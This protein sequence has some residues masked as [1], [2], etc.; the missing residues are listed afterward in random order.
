MCPYKAI[1]FD[2]EKKKSS[3][4]E[5]LCKGCGTCV[6]SCGSNAIFQNLFDDEEI[7]SELD[8]LLIEE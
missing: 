1:T 3:V 7:L 6:A 5:A 4:N 8:G 2:P